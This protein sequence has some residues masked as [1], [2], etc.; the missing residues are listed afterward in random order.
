MPWFRTLLQSVVCS[1][2]CCS[3]AA[4]AAG[5]ASDKAA[6]SVWARLAAGTPQDLIVVFDDAAIQALAAKMNM[7]KALPFDGPETLR[8]KMR[9]YG[10]IKQ[11]V[12]A[13][14]SLGDY[15]V[16]DSYRSLPMMYLR[17]RSAAALKTLL[18]NPLVMNAY[19][20]RTE[21]PMAQKGKP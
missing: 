5:T 8:F 1:L 9:R 3:L 7:E 21:A 18:S 2:G 11:E 20:S 16:L 17:I 10:E 13:S 19:E 6:Q 12:F 4:G 15:E 14:L